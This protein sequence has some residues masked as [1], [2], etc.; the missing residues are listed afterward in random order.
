[1]VRKMTGLA[2]GGLWG[3]GPD[4]VEQAAIKGRDRVNVVNGINERINVVI[5]ILLIFLDGN[6]KQSRSILDP[7]LIA[8]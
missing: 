8:G 3:A 5:M 7:K 6:A 2:D 1:M 4:I